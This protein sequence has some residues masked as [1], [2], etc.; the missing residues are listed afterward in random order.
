ML[1]QYSRFG[2]EDIELASSAHFLHEKKKIL[3]YYSYPFVKLQYQ[4]LTDSQDIQL[5]D[6]KIPV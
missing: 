1:P 6:L 3:F 4:T 5:Y 2:P